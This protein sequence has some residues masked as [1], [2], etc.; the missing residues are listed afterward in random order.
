MM[1]FTTLTCLSAA[2]VVMSA[3]TAS[4]QIARTRAPANGQTT[5]ATGGIPRDPQFPYAGLWQGTRTM[6]LGAGDV[7]LRFTV[8]D[9]AYAG[10]MVH[11]DGG[12][13]PHRRLVATAAGLTWESPNSGGGTWVYKVRL[14][15][16]DSMT[17]TLTLRDPPPNLTP[18]PSGT[19]VLVRTRARNER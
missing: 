12:E 11:P 1:R 13:A 2:L 3:T 14:A 19:M 10:A 8:V 15:G 4:A 17:G 16:P 18:A 6:P 5:P 9:G 7:V